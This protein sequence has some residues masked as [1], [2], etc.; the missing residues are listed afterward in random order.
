M[1]GV[2]TVDT[3]GI[4]TKIQDDALSLNI[5]GKFWMICDSGSC[6]RMKVAAGNRIIKAF[7]HLCQKR[8]CFSAWDE[9][10]RSDGTPGG[11]TTNH[12][13]SQSVSLWQQ[14]VGCLPGDV[15]VVKS[16]S[17]WRGLIIIIIL[18]N[19]SLVGTLRSQPS[20][21]STM[22]TNTGVR[23]IIFFSMSMMSSWSLA[24]SMN[25]SRVISPEGSKDR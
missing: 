7:R 3:S 12:S 8:V 9:E 6:R 16:F 22:M 2:Q 25:S 11:W 17:F 24:P 19:E 23:S 13:P 14:H 5:S 10:E 18:N 4:M 1:K 21:P 15:R 20:R